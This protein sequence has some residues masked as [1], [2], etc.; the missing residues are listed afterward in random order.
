[1]TDDNP[2]ARGVADRRGPVKPI[3]AV[4]RSPAVI[5]VEKVLS[6]SQPG[7]SPM[8][9]LKAG[10]KAIAGED[11][12]WKSSSE[13]AYVG[14][15]FQLVEKGFTVDEALGFMADAYSAA[16]ECFGG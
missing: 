3:P 4:Y 6:N 11:G 5:V 7:T 13:E 9:R 16:A 12:W 10:I 1:M 14:M 8:E 2:I 15:A